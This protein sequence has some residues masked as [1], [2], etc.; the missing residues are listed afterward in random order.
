M[1]EKRDRPGRDKG[2]A[3]SGGCLRS[4]GGVCT[5]SFSGAV[6]VTVQEHWDGY[7]SMI[8]GKEISVCI[9][10]LSGYG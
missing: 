7:M 6:K 4:G 5:K 8:T 1:I 9:W 10:Y 3:L 2:L